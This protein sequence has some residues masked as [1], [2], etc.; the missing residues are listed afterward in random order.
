M[1]RSFLGLC[2]RFSIEPK[3]MVIKMVPISGI[4]FVQSV[5][6]NK[7]KGSIDQIQKQLQGFYKQCALLRPILEVD[8]VC[9]HSF[10]SCIQCFPNSLPLCPVEFTS[11]ICRFKA[12]F[13]VM[14]TILLPFLPTWPTF[15]VLNLEKR[16][17]HTF[18]AIRIC[19]PK[20][21]ERLE[22]NSVWIA[23]LDWIRTFAKARNR[24]CSNWMQR[25]KS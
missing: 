5:D 13:R 6:V 12:F 23:A 21:A 16:R 11:T 3:P 19:S 17:F 7:C 24:H 14:K 2:R 20:R 25:N 22:R 1:I 8:S 18:N 4:D 9:L 15:L 10:L